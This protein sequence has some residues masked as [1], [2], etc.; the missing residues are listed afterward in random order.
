MSENAITKLRDEVERVDIRDKDIA[1]IYK[2]ATIHVS[3]PS[4]GAACIF[5]HD[6]G[7]S[8]ETY[9]ACT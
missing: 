8:G 7:G 9:H 5:L 3:K 6:I 2:P 1:P 4:D